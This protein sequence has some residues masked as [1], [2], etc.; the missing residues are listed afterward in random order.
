MLGSLE[1]HSCYSVSDLNLG[2]VTRFQSLLYDVMEELHSDSPWIETL[3]AQYSIDVL[4]SLVS[5][6][7][8]I[9][10]TVFSPTGEL[11]ALGI[12]RH[13]GGL[14]TISWIAVDERY[15]N[16]SLGSQVL[17]AMLNFYQ[18]NG[19]HRVE[20]KTYLDKPKVQNFYKNKG[21]DYAAVLPNHKFGFD[22][23][24][25]IRDIPHRAEHL[26]EAQ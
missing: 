5:A 25:M 1:E 13:D 15:R 24:Y 6:D 26:E 20:L 14:G 4:R 22:I 2:N 3:K 16:L 12:G 9:C 17:D 11:I 7:F 10:P 8:A 23:V 21:F 18:A 19:C